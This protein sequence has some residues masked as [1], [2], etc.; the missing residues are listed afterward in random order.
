VDQI[1][2]PAGAASELVFR[3]EPGKSIRFESGSHPVAAILRV[4]WPQ[5]ADRPS[6]L[7]LEKKP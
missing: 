2:R 3:I 5:G 4:E 6:V 7:S 1:A